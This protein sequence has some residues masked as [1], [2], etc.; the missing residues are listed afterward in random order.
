MLTTMIV[1]TATSFVVLAIGFALT[2]S[3]SGASR[4]M[5]EQEAGNDVVRG[6]LERGTPGR[7]MGVRTA[8]RGKAVG[9]QRTTEYSFAEIKEAIRNGRVGDVMP[10]LMAVLGMFGFLFFGTIIVWLISN[11]VIGVLLLGGVV[12]AVVRTAIAFGMA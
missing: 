2:L 10:I 1:L 6:M 4:Q 8:F 12:Y 9:T 5:G 3:R 7:M 11:P